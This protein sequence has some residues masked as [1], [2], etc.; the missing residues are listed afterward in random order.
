MKRNNVCATLSELKKLLF[1]A[2]LGLAL[3][4]HDIGPAAAA[5]VNIVALGA[6]NTYGKGVSRSESYP[7]QL[8]AML[9][10]RGYD[11]NVTNAGVNGDT[12]GGMLSRLGSAI[13]DGTHLVLFMPGKNDMRKGDP[14]NRGA[15]IAEIK[16]RLHARGIKVMMV[17]GAKSSMPKQYIQ[18]DGIHL[19]PEGCRLIAARML[20]QVTATIGRR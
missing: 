19:T 1:G 18:P 5:R 20:P 4:F 7:A 6:S 2:F 12:T 3:L 11:V 15:N 14:R 9:R 16:R 17:Q 13:P 10:A 8:E